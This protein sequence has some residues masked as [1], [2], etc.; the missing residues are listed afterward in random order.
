MTLKILKKYSIKAKKSLWQ[1]FLVSEEILNS[2]S[3]FLDISWKN[4][5]EVWPGYWALTEKLLKEKP[6]SLT[7]VELDDNMVSI[8]EDRIDNWELETDW[9]DFNIKNTD[10]LK[11]TPAFSNYYVIANIPY[12]ITSPILRH[13]L[14]DIKNVP[15]NMLI[16]MQKDVADKILWNWKNKS[17]VLS[18]FINK[19]CFTKE[20][21]IVPKESFIPA[22]KVESSVLLF[23]SHSLYSDIDDERFLELIKKW[24]SEPRKKL[25]KNL[26]KWWFEKEVILKAFDNI[27]VWENIRAEDLDIENWLKIFSYFN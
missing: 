3:S 23:K 17:S 14:Y 11:F 26:I 4:I 24:F 20:V 13:F 10:V 16:L 6:N 27:W 1:N 8:L 25:I 22:P 2:I 7:L 12:Y 18:L 15:Q 19:K 9:I 21:I 5:L